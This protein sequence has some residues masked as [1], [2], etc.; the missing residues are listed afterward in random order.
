MPHTLRQYSDFIR[1]LRVS[2][3]ITHLKDTASLNSWMSQNYGQF[4]TCLPQNCVFR[5]KNQQNPE[6]SIILPNTSVNV[7]PHLWNKS[8][9]QILWK[10][11]RAI[12]CAPPWSILY[13]WERCLP[14]MLNC[15]S[16]HFTTVLRTSEFTQVPPSPLT[17]MKGHFSWYAFLN[18]WKHLLSTGDGFAGARSTDSAKWHSDS[19]DLSGL[20]LRRCDVLFGRLEKL[21]LL[22]VFHTPAEQSESKSAYFYLSHMRKTSKSGFSKFLHKSFSYSQGKSEKPCLFVVS[23]IKW[24]NPE[25]LRGYP[26]FQNAQLILMIF[27]NKYGRA[28]TVGMYEFHTDNV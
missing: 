12:H 13:S 21:F 17:V 3:E 25:L 6:Q 11:Q 16:V 20:Q 9:Y 7:S 14:I 19:E 28:A 26:Y 22:L 1:Y 2:R 18:I 15:P 8:S 27:Q 23:W 24:Q 5:N 10:N 4:R